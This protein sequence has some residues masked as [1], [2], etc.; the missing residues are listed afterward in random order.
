MH[1]TIIKHVKF[2]TYKSTVPIIFIYHNCVYATNLCIRH[3]PQKGL[4]AANLH[5]KAHLNVPDISSLDSLEHP[6]S[7]SQP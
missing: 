4:K 7:G 2:N 5:I 6:L 3:I 1:R